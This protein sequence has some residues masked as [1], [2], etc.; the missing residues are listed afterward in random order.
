MDKPCSRINEAAFPRGKGIHYLIAH[1]IDGVL[2]HD[3]IEKWKKRGP[4]K[5]LKRAEEA[6]SVFRV[7]VSACLCDLVPSNRG[8]TSKE[9]TPD[10]AETT[11]K[12]LPASR[13]RGKKVFVERRPIEELFLLRMTFIL[14][15]VHLQSL[16]P[17]VRDFSLKKR[18][19]HYLDGRNN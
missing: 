14:P 17:Y 3:W 7:S 5:A 4:A 16:Q 10:I 6:H 9:L 1:L 12:R 8:G 15:Y 18:R 2:H 11:I 19:L 13:R